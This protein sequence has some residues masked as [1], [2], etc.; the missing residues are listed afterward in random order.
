MKL[1]EKVFGRSTRLSPNSIFD[2]YNPY[3]IEL[4][5]RLRLGLSHLN[6]HNFT[7]GFNDTINPIFICG[8]DIE[9]ISY[10]FLHCPEYCETRQT[11]FYNIQSIGKTL[12]SAK[13]SSLT[14]LLLYSDPKR[15]SIFNALIFNSAIKFILSSGKFSGSLFSEA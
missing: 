4:F 3:G 5:T 11:L 12:L 7:Y 1:S 2:I 9:S 6:E 14:R 10:F 13:K 8:S 15:Y